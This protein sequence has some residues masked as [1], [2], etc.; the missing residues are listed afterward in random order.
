MAGVENA[1]KTSNSNWFETGMDWVGSLANT[2]LQVWGGIEQVKG[3]QEANK[4]KNE[5]TQNEGQVNLAL[6]TMNA[7]NQRF[8]QSALVIGGLA[9]AGI[10]IYKMF[11]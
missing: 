7:Q 1:A 10:L 5:M 2:G 8:L 9:I 3:Q 4:I 11:K 6:A